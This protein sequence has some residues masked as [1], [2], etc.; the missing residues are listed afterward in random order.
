MT[1][2]GL[3]L[4]LLCCRPENVPPPPRSVPLHLRAVR[5]LRPAAGALPAAGGLQHRQGP[6]RCHGKPRFLRPACLQGGAGL[7]HVSD[8]PFVHNTLS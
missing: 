5:W 4:V 2:V 3:T 7:W 6:E 8:P 1:C